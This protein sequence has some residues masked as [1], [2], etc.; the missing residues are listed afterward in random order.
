MYLK[1]LDQPPSGAGFDRL[2]GLKTDQ[3]RPNPY[4]LFEILPSILRL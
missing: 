4:M 1:T 3:I 2:K